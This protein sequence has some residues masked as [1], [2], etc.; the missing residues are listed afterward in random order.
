MTE[1]AHSIKITDTTISSP[2]DSE[3]YSKCVPTV[4]DN[5]TTIEKIVDGLQVFQ[6]FYNLIAETTDIYVGKINML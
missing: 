4:Y 6:T 1:I 3:T 2:T 5:K